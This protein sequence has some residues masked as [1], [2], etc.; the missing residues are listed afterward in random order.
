M[1][2]RQSSND[3]KAKKRRKNVIHFLSIEFCDTINLLLIVS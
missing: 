2:Q 1:T 3:K